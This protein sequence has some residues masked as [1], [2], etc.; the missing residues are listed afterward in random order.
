MLA[1]FARRVFPSTHAGGSNR[2]RYPLL[3]NKRGKLVRIGWDEALATMAENSRVQEKYGRDALG[4]LSTGQL[5]T[6]E[7]TRSQAGAA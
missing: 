6:E 1:C 4:V 5:V 3:R 2:A 7:F